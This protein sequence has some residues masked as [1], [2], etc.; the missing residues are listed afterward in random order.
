MQPVSPMLYKKWIVSLWPPI[1]IIIYISIYIHVYNHWQYII[2]NDNQ[3]WWSPTD[4]TNKNLWQRRDSFENA[5]NEWLLC[6]DTIDQRLERNAPYFKWLW[7]ELEWKPNCVLNLKRLTKTNS[8]TYG[9]RKDRASLAFAHLLHRA[10]R[11][12]NGHFLLSTPTYL[13]LKT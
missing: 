9:E 10:V 13:A 7:T 1:N 8:L 12:A 2:F 3:F 4:H 11:A 5:R 6:F